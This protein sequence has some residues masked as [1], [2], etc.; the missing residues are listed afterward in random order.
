MDTY[1][2]TREAFNRQR[3]VAHEGAAEAV[4]KKTTTSERRGDGWSWVPRD[5]GREQQ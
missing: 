1:F 3:E 4:K 5:A 2:P